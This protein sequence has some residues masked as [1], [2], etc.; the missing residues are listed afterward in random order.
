MLKNKNAK[1]CVR[2]L[3]EKLPLKVDGPEKSLKT[4]YKAVL[5]H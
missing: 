3:T 1:K 4:H 2:V 5:R